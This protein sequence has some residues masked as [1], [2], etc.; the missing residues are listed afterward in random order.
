MKICKNCGAA[1]GIDESVCALCGARLEET[2][3]IE[4]PD[5]TYINPEEAIPDT[6]YTEPKE[7]IPDTSYT[8][9]VEMGQSDDLQNRTASEITVAEL[10]TAT[11]DIRDAEMQQ[12]NNAAGFAGTVP[13]RIC[14]FCG[15]YI[16][17]TDKFCCFCGQ[18][19]NTPPNQNGVPLGGYG[20]SNPIPNAY[21]NPYSPQSAGSGTVPPFYA[22]YAP[23]QQQSKKH[24]WPIVLAIS[25]G[26]VVLCIILLAVVFL[27]AVD[28]A[29]DEL[30]ISDAAEDYAYVLYLPDSY[31]PLEV[32]PADCVTQMMNTYALDESEFSTQLSNYIYA[33]I[34]LMGDAIAEPTADGKAWVTDYCTEMDTSFYTSEMP[35]E[36]EERCK[37][38]L[39]D[40]GIEADRF[41]F[42]SLTADG[43]ETDEVLCMAEID[44][45]WYC[46]DAILMA[47]AM[48][49]ENQAVSDLAVDYLEAW[50]YEDAT[51]FRT[52]VPDAYWDYLQESFSLGKE[53]AIA[54]MALYVDGGFGTDGLSGLLEVDP[55]NPVWYDEA[56]VAMWT[57]VYDYD[58]A[59]EYC[60]DVTCDFNAA[61]TYDD[62]ANAYTVTM[63]SVDGQWYVLDAMIDYLD[64]YYYEVEGYSYDYDYGYDY[65]YD[66]GYDYGFDADY[67][68]NQQAL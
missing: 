45:S 8:D 9:S 59:Y 19:L 24:V 27:R 58:I 43:N 1:L 41:I 2:E 32:L 5:A 10:E 51:A 60:V 47:E 42:A 12:P 23:I 25:L 29:V 66:Y 3:R 56:D 57:D 28:T 54:Y 18:N 31:D 52:M 61:G 53:E 49:Q 39:D 55:G 7:A 30:A 65:D 34:P 50:L 6:T 37:A 26:L 67:G 38:V 48:C 4:E 21:P 63:V 62:L 22:G 33:E 17:P 11:A 16:E 44:E 46:V 15:K 40:Y 36:T 64:A 35:G 13:P 68:D 20:Y 14:P